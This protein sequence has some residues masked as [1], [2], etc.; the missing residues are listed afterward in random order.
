[1]TLRGKFALASAAVAAVTVAVTVALSYDATASLIKVD[2]EQTFRALVDQ[3]STSSLTLQDFTAP[4]DRDSLVSKLTTSRQVVTQVVSPQGT[5]VW[6]DPDQ[7]VLPVPADPLVHLAG[8]DYTVVTVPLRAG[9][10]VQIAQR[11][12]ETNHLLGALGQ[13]LLF[14][15]LGVFVLAGLVGW[16]VATRVT[17]RLARLTAAVSRVTGTG[18]L[19]VPVAVS[20]RDEVARLGAAFETMLTELREAKAAQERLVADASHE[21]RTPLTS[22]RT[23]VTVLRRFSELSPDARERLVADLDGETRELSTLVSQLVSSATG[24]HVGSSP[25]QVSLVDV[26]SRV[27]DVVRRRTGRLVRVD[28]AGEVFGQAEGL[29]RALTNLVENAAKF[30]TSGTIE[31]VARPD[32]IAVL[33]RGPGVGADA[34]RIFDR[35]YRATAARGLPGSGLGLAIVAEVARVHGGQVFARDRTGG[36]AEVGFTL[37]GPC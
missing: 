17:R 30:A 13:L 34:P 14:V 9:G 21:L 29:T 22:L 25:V 28:A 19:D 31:V 33:D 5:V 20:G 10:S 27:A 2:T 4:A 12:T 36:G 11:T 35:F 15:G 7:V 3:V 37:A 18:D 1:M 32:R 24:A 6:R 16:L 8:E 26:A 23:N